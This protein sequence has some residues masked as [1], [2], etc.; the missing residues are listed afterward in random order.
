MSITRNARDWFLLVFLLSDEWYD[1]GLMQGRQLLYVRELYL[2]TNVKDHGK[3][4]E[5]IGFS[6][7]QRLKKTCL[8]GFYHSFPYASQ[9]EY[10]GIFYVNDSVAY[11]IVSQFITV[12]MFYCIFA[13][14]VVKGSHIIILNVGRFFVRVTE[15]DKY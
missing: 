7:A 11:K 10:K 2:V 9:L 1:S 5:L 8:C 15:P 12:Q 3:K 4:L 14:C 13:Q 6:S